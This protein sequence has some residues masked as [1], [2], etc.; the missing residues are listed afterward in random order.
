MAMR[1]LGETLDI[2]VGGVDNMFPH[3]ENEIAQSE[4]CSGK[5]FSK[6]WLHSEHLLVDHKKMSK[7]LGNFYTFRMLK[8]KGFT[9]LQ[10][11]LL[12]LQTHYKTQL[13][14][15]L[16]GLEG[17]KS[18]LQRINGFIQRLQEVTTTADTPLLPPLIEKAEKAFAEALAD[19]LNISPALA[20][21][22]DFI[23]D[24]NTLLDQGAISRSQ[25]DQ[26][27][28]F[29]RSLDTVLGI[30]TFETEESIPE[31]VEKAFH[32]RQ[33][34]RASKNWARADELRA[35]IKDHGWV[36]EDTPTGAR[37]KKL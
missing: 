26:I 12:L 10:L 20:A 28:S 31:A 19:D 15:T 27:L 24:G 3:H 37:L 2:H 23:R 18:S 13:N 14:F 16:A 7:S 21:L 35:V 5:T 17:T 8:E 36:I 9:G 1:L 34:A 4:A 25:S 22:Y 11:R 33:E 32:D 30:M 29:L 6:M